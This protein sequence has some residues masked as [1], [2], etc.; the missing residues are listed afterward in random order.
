MVEVQIWHHWK[1][2]Q[3]DNNLG[4]PRVFS[5]QSYCKSSCQNGDKK[6]LKWKFYSS[7]EMEQNAFKN[8]HPIYSL[9]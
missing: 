6:S 5:I 4:L 8:M 3:C 2:V 9:E 1:I 7:N